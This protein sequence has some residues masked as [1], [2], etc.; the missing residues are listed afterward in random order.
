MPRVNINFQQTVIYKIENTNKPELFYI[1]HTTDFVKRK[2]LHKTASTKEPKGM[3]KSLH[4]MIQDNGGFDVFKMLEIKKFSCLDKNEADAEAWR[5]TVEN[6]QEQLKLACITNEN[7]I[8]GG[9]F[10]PKLSYRG[11]NTLF[12]CNC[13]SVFTPDAKNKHVGTAKHLNYDTSIKNKAE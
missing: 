11:Q 5:I 7:K 6:K 1:G 12:T 2:N 9:T 3:H 4:Q 8:K 13:G 10:I